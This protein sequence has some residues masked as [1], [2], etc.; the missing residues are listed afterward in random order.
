MNAAPYRRASGIVTKVGTPLRGVPYSFWTIGVEGWRV[1]E[2]MGPLGEASLPTND[3][4]LRGL[5]GNFLRA[6]L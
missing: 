5:T 2:Q 1:P 4:P 6:F 3:R